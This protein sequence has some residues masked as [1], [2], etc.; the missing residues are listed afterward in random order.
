MNELTVDDIKTLEQGLDA[1]QAKDQS[2]AM[3]AGLMI[4]VLTPSKEE[5][6]RSMKEL[7]AEGKS[8]SEAIKDKVTLLRAKLVMIREKLE[9]QEAADFMKDGSES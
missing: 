7:L 8:K 6:E 2:D 5:A 9:A 1:L 3:L 4:G